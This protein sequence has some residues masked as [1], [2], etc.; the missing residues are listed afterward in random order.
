M[1][2]TL[3]VDFSEMNFWGG[4]LRQRGAFGKITPERAA[5]ITRLLA[6]EFFS[7]ELLGRKSLLLSGDSQPIAGVTVRELRKP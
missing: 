4:P 7:Q 1:A 2:G 5:E 3:H 6:R